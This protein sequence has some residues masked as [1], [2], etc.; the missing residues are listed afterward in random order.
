MALRKHRLYLHVNQETIERCLYQ[1]RLP[2][3]MLKGF[4]V[5]LVFTFLA[6]T[7]KLISDLQMMNN[8]KLGKNDFNL[9][10]AQETLVQ[11]LRQAKV[12]SAIALLPTNICWK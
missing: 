5:F 12:E 1:D 7:P 3:Y 2:V 4:D 11:I 6:G 8:V 9:L 10:N